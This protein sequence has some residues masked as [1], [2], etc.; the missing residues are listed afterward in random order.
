MIIE[1]SVFIGCEEKYENADAV[2]FGAPFDGTTSF[3]PGT[4]FAPAVMRQDSYGL[5]TYSPYLDRDMSEIKVCDAGDL[6]F[7]FG[8]PA[9]VLDEVE[10]FVDN[11]LNDGKVPIMLGGEHLLTL[12]SVRAVQKRFK[13]LH[14]I[15]FDAHTDLREEYLGE[16]LSHAAVIR[17]IYDILGDGRVHQFGIRSGEKHEFEFANRHTDMHKFNLD[18]LEETVEKLKRYP[19]YITID[20]DVLDPSIFPGTGTPEPGGISF[21]ELQRAIAI[22]GKLNVVGFD[23][24]ELSPHYDQSG[25]STAAACKALREMMLSCL[26]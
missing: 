18:G 3:R 25:I 16:D 13:N 8:N 21:V 14:V 4:R 24:C 2:I 10:G 11:V 17:K 23:V 7:P 5:E 26:K 6:E 20:L 12:G 1:N 22:M 15:Q 9:K 19:V